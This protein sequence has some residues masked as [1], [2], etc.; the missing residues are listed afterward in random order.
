[1]IQSPG[2]RKTLKIAIREL[3]DY[4]FNAWKEEVVITTVELLG[5]HRGLTA[6]SAQISEMAQGLQR[7]RAHH[8]FH[9]ELV[10]QLS[11]SID[12]QTSRKQRRI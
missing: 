11:V 12:L 2:R 3:S 9:G 4:F 10:S 5:G 1:V 8:D 6:P 7:T